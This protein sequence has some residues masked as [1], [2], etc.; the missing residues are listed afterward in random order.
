[1]NVLLMMSSVAMGGAERNIVSLLPYL[2]TPN[3]KTML[4]TMNTRRDSPLANADSL[5]HIE[6]FDLGA[7]RML[8]I[9]AFKKLLSIIRKQEIDVIH[10]QDQD[11]I[12]YAGLASRLLG[13]PSVM[14]RHVLDESDINWRKRIR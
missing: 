10:A 14:T 2:Q 9:R 8:D 5:S 13:R 4:C 3:V 12:I 7:K 11:T 1:M 6:R